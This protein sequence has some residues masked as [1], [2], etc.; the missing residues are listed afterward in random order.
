MKENVLD[1]LM[2]LFENYIYEEPD[3]TPDRE[4]LSDSLEEAGFSSV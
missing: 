1:L 3:S 4:S 2:Y